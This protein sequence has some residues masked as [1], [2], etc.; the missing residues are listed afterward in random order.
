MFV[1]LKNLTGA[2]QCRWLHQAWYWPISVTV[3]IIKLS[4]ISLKQFL[5]NAWQ[6]ISDNYERK[7]IRFVFLSVD[8]VHVKR[9]FFLNIK[10]NYFCFNYCL[11]TQR[12]CPWPVTKFTW[13]SFRFLI[14]TRHQRSRWWLAHFRHQSS[15][16][17]DSRGSHP[18]LHKN[19]Q[20]ARVSKAPV[21]DDL[22]TF[23]SMFH[24]PSCFWSKNF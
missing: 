16:L 18:R 2:L 21:P 24:A 4:S 8:Y 11:R 15:A 19:F 17:A 12:D 23:Q 1:E 5:K 9:V 13:P 10:I 14:R 7:K 3:E 6:K 20:P 22:S